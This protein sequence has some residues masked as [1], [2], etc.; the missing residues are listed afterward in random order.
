LAEKKEAPSWY[1]FGRWRIRLGKFGFGWRSAAR[2]NHFK[3][4]IFRFQREPVIVLRAFSIW[5]QWG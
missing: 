5:V 3:G 4:K 2:S 1:Y